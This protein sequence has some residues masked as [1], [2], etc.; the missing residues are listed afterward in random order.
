[1]ATMRVTS[2]NW[3]LI[4]D[5]ISNTIGHRPFRKLSDGAVYAVE[6]RKV[7]GIMRTLRLQNLGVCV[8][9]ADCEYG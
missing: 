5:K 3:S 8:T 1:M 6:T 9:I 4:K 7:D 2:A